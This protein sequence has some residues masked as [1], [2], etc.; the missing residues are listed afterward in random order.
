MNH[1]KNT[2]SKNYSTRSSSEN[3][4]KPIPYHFDEIRPEQATIDE[5]MWR[6]GKADEERISG[7]LLLSLEAL[8]PLFVG[9][10]Q[11]KLD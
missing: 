3:H 4:L 2:K 5:P 10:H 6:D 1:H 7:E 8:T 11:K 9:N